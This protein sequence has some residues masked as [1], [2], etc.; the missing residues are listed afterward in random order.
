MWRFSKG[1]RLTENHSRIK[2]FSKIQMFFYNSPALSLATLSLSRVTLMH[3]PVHTEIS[4]FP[5]A[6]NAQKWR[7]AGRTLYRMLGLQKNMIVWSRYKTKINFQNKNVQFLCVLDHICCSGF[8]MA[9]VLG[10]FWIGLD[11]FV[12]LW[13]LTIITL[14]KT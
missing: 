3:R 2:A 6:Y 10:S 12:F 13:I 14:L 7:W 1:P 8:F 11:H 4:Y 5:R 9:A